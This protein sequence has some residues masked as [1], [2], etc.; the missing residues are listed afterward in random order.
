M[1]L[2]HHPVFDLPP[3]DEDV[4]AI[5]SGAGA[6]TGILCD[7]A[8][9]FASWDGKRWDLPDHEALLDLVVHLWTPLPKDPAAILDL[10]GE[11]PE[12]NPAQTRY[13]FRVNVCPVCKRK[14]IVSFDESILYAGSAECARSPVWT[15]RCEPCGISCDSLD[16]WNKLRPVGEDKS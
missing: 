13:D 4:L 16:R 12:C 11:K 3:I 1:K 14:P 9:L 15:I 10:D 5:V 2:W 6:E 7:R 8:M